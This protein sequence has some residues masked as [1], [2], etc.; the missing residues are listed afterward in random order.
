[1]E[2]ITLTGVQAT[3]KPHIGNYI[4]AIRPALALARQTPHCFM[5]IADYH[6]LNAVRDPVALRDDIYGVAATFL[7]AGLDPEKT[8]FYRQSAVPEIFELAVLLSA[9]TPKGLMDRAHAYKAAVDR[10]KAEG[11]DADHEVNMGLYTYPILMAADILSMRATTV[12]VGKD[13]IQHIEFAR[14]IAGY[15][16]NAFSK[17]FPLPEYVV[18]SMDEAGLLPGIDGRKMSKSYKNHI[19]LFMPAD[20]RRKLVMKIISDSK[21][22]EDPKDPDESVI[23]QMYRHFAS[24]EEVSGMRQRFL[25]GGIGY[26]TAKQALFDVLDRELAAPAAIYADYMADPAKIDALLAKGAEKARRAAGDTLKL[27]RRAV[28][29]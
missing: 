25:E 24:A 3:G 27:A 9:V 28:G 4:G 29:L 6:A 2:K 10:N 18:S 22:P 8:V 23:F 20:E 5:F 12:P 7:A 15:F 17:I 19:P 14:D 21:R 13:Q 16:N 26:G 1:M 11:R